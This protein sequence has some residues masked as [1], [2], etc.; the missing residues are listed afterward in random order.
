MQLKYNIYTQVAQ[1]LQL[2]KAKLQESTPAF[3]VIQA[4]SVPIKSSN[5]KKIYI[6]I[7]FMILGFATRIVVLALKN[8]DSLFSYNS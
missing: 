8:K 1:Q 6:L 3:T 5:F 7:L 4:V 2:A